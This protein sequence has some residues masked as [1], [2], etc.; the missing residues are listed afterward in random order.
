MKLMKPLI[1]G[2]ILLYEMG[3]SSQ[4]KDGPFTWE[5]CENIFNN[6]VDEILFDVG[7]TS[8]PIF[9]LTNTPY[10]NSVLNKRR[11]FVDE[12]EVEYVPNFREA[13]SVTKEYKGGRKQD[14]PYHFYN[15]IT[16]MMSEHEVHINEQGLE[17]DDAICIELTSNP[18]AI[19]CSR[20]K[21]LRQCPGMHYSWQ[22][23]AQTSIGPY[24]VEGLGTLERIVKPVKNAKGVWEDKL[25][26]K[27][28]GT[29]AKLFYYQMLT[30]DPVDNIQGIKGIGPV[31]AVKLLA[32]CATERELFDV[33]YGI[34]EEKY[35]EDCRTHFRE[36]ADLLW[37]IREIKDGV[38]V[39]WKV[40]K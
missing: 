36:M 7:A 11:R 19:A 40:P 20:D 10:L 4:D 26:D 25:T 18:D 39:K 37:M 16:Y 5:H 29:G 34:Y 38:P 27:V 23:G 9:Y 14:K 28:F 33:V 31:N 22:C 3:F 13:V 30:G 17:A 24:L 21:D 32:D 6:R 35:G 15:L 1:D 8:P 12:P 2:D